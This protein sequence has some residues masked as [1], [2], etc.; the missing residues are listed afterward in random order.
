MTSAPTAL[1]E[2]SKV[3]MAPRILIIE[4]ENAAQGALRQRFEYEGYSVETA[5]SGKQGLALLRSTPPT[6]IIL[7]AQLPD[8]S[9]LEVF[10]RIQRLAPSTP[11]IVLSARSSVAEKVLFLD[12]GA[13]DYVTKPFSERELLARLRAAMRRVVVEPGERLFSFDDVTVDFCKMELVRAGHRVPLTALEFKVLKFMTH[14]A[15]RVISR[16]ELLNEV[17]GYQNYPTTRTVDNHILRLRQKLEKD[18]S[19]PVHF[20][21]V[22]SMGYRFVLA[23]TEDWYGEPDLP[24]KKTD[25]APRGFH[26][27][28]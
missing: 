6:A 4:D 15:G 26:C 9:G 23:E 28:A 2:M 10:R 5:A 11:I 1:L 22:H 3:S 13:H 21:T 8:I 12:L 16:S 24:A 7:D 17:W 18:P 25:R 14:N 19:N 27:Q 20:Q